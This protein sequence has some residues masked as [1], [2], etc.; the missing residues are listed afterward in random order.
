MF[1]FV[2][3]AYA[4]FLEL[5]DIVRN[6]GDGGSD[7]EE[8]MAPTGGENAQASFD[9]GVDKRFL[10]EG[11]HR[12]GGVEVGRKG[13]RCT[14]D[15]YIDRVHH[16]LVAGI[17]FKGAPDIGEKTV[18]LEFGTANAFTH[19]TLDHVA[20]NIDIMR[21]D[22]CIPRKMGP[23]DNEVTVIE[24]DYGLV[25]TGVADG[26]P[27][28]IAGFVA[29]NAAELEECHIVGVLQLHRT[30]D[31]HSLGFGYGVTC[32]VV[33]HLQAIDAGGI[34]HVASRTGVD[35]LNGI[36]EDSRVLVGDKR[37]IKMIDIARIVPVT[38][39]ATVV[40]DPCVPFLHQNG[41]GPLRI[42]D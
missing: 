28:D 3:E 11:A 18:L 36:V 17:P 12:M 9:I 15:V 32:G 41:E 35:R 38:M 1:T 29:R 42:V 5:F 20:G 10:V 16:I 21:R 25:L 6:G 19:V 26:G 33:Y 7:T 39:I 13:L 40:V 31:K 4:Q 37:V 2:S 27:F 24:A 14:E 30:P 22:G 34:Q 23:I 8:D